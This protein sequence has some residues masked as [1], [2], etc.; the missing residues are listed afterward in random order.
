[1]FIVID[2][3]ATLCGFDCHPGWLGCTNTGPHL[4]GVPGNP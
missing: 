3:Q 2:K 4:N 1:V